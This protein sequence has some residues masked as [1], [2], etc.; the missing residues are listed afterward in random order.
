MWLFILGVIINSAAL[1]VLLIAIFSKRLSNALI[2][3]AVNVL[4]FFKVKNIEEKRDKL[5]QGLISYQDS[6]KYIKTHKK[7]MLLTLFTTCAQIIFYYSIPYW[8]YRA[9]GLQALNIFQII[10]IQATLYTISAGLPLPGA[11]GVSEGSFIAIFEKVFESENIN[12][13]MLL[14]RGVSFYLFVIISGI[15]VIS[16]II[17]YK[18]KKL[19]E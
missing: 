11:V 6:A 4:K 18:E 15:V 12:S 19:E 17:K 2:K 1:I 16:N 13:A 8:I 9:F 5:E 3:F 10:A 14:S 7:V